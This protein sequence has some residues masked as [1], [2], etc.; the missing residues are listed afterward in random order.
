[1]QSAALKLNCLL[2]NLEEEDYDKA[3]SYIE[4]LVNVRKKEKNHSFYEAYTA[5]MAS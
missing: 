5:C 4:Y 3:V 2:E 1:M